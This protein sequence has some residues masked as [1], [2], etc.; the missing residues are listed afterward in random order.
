[1]R[2]VHPWS[3]AP[4]TPGDSAELRL[5]LIHVPAHGPRPWSARR[6]Q[7]V[8]D[9][10]AASCDALWIGDAHQLDLSRAVSVHST[11]TRHP[12]YREWL[13]A[14][15]QCAPPIAWLPDPPRPCGSFSRYYAEVQRQSGSLSDTLACTPW[16]LPNQLS[17]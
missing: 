16:P 13:A 4:R 10:L 12:G 7:W 15:T 8:I 17:L 3:L 6:W 14:H 11:A 9:H 1:M 5:G 2:I